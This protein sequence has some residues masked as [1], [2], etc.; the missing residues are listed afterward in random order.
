M[1]Y[2]SNAHDYEH[3]FEVFVQSLEISALNIHKLNLPPVELTLLH[4]DSENIFRL[5]LA[6]AQIRNSLIKFFSAIVVKRDG[7]KIQDGLLLKQI[8]HAWE[9]HNKV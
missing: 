6:V 5:Y 1:V 3:Y 4:E 9:R 7:I 8:K 2:P